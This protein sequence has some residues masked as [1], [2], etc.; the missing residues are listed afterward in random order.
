MNEELPS[1]LIRPKPDMSRGE[2]NHKRVVTS[3]LRVGRF[4]NNTPI[5]TPPLIIS[6]PPTDQGHTTAPKTEQQNKPKQQT[7]ITAQQQQ[8]ATSLGA[9]A[10]RQIGEA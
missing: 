1:K 3:G 10:S 5:I 4:S 9:A 2:S 6:T 8:P 7:K